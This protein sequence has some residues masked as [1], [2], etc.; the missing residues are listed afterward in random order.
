MPTSAA[1]QNAP[2][3]LCAALEI[4]LN[5]YLRLEPAA[6]QACAAL[7][8]RRIGVE[9]RDFGWTFVVELCAGGA[10]V[11]DRPASEA[12]VCVSAASAA[13][14]GQ[15][16]SGLRG[17]T[18]AQPGVQF[19]G[20][21]ELLARFQHLLARVGFEPEEWLAPLLGEGAAHRLG[22]GLRGLFGWGRYAASRLS[23]D[24][25]EY[26]REETG[27]LAGAADVEVWAQDVEALRSRADR[28][29]ARLALLETRLR[30]NTTAA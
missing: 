9:L 22:N 17:Q 28:F 8:G 24:A 4:A 3:L 5:R 25:A 16:L 30:R 15:A 26:L 20:D 23:L 2:A 29:E 6:V 14:L 12:E 27:T 18:Q 19:S 7:D 21:I 10:R 11:L 13:L 1:P